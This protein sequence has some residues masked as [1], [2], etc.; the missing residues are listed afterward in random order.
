MNK[1][2]GVSACPPFEQRPSVKTLVATLFALCL[3]SCSGRSAG[4]LPP[5][6]APPASAQPTA[7]EYRQPPQLPDGWRTASASDVGLGHVPLERMTEAICRGEE[8]RNIHAVL[9]V[10]D[11]QLVYEEYFAGEDEHGRRGTLGHVAFDRDT[12][13]DMRSVTKNVMSALVGIAIGSGVLRSVDQPLL[14]FFPEH[15][16]LATPERRAI[17]LRHALDMS[18]GL[19][20]NEMLPGSDSLN[21]AARMNRSADLVRFVWE[22]PIVAAPGQRWSYSGG[23]T[24]LLA[25]AV[26]R[27][28]NRPLVEFAHEVLFEPLG[29]TDVE[30]YPNRGRDS[31]DADSGLRLRPRDMAKLGLLYQQQGRWNGRQIVPADW[32]AASLRRA[33]ALPDSLVE[34]GTGATGEL[35]YGHQWWHARYTLPYGRFTAHRAAGN[36]GQL[37]FVVPEQQ[38]VAVV[39][40]GLY[41]KQHDSDRLVLERILPW[42]LGLDTS[43]HFWPERTVRL[44][45]PGDRPEVMLQ[46]QE[47]LSYVGT[48]DHDGA[49]VRVWDEAG[50]L[51]MTGFAGLAGD[52][53]HL[54]PLGGH[55]FACGRYEGGRLVKVYWPD[56]RIEF[57]MEDGRATRFIDRT[58]GGHV[59]GTAARVP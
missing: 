57:V 47:R 12:P 59:Y 2:S 8:Y 58:A 49:R 29:I 25:E 21:A 52:P 17:T 11:G 15:A 14:D 45:S 51:H 54:V 6:L 30:W 13:H 33:I 36:G 26:R 10:K 1:H 20:W 3:V 31:P 7:S 32:V 40:A 42:A 27:A 55:V 46:A 9:V 5:V 22:Q 48:Y 19:D 18:A 28:T 38:L 16:E 34:F 39:T 23:L 50:V 41:D 35:G 56:D 43:Y 44:V 4:G 37:I 24:Q 53:I